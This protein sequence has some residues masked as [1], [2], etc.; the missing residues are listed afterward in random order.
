MKRSQGFSIDECRYWIVFQITG[1]YL[2]FTGIPGR[3]V[4]NRAMSRKIGTDG[5]PMSTDWSRILYSGEHEN[6]PSLL[7]H[8]LQDQI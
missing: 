5:H 4:E 3:T 8:L 7:L 6:D 1:T 2:T